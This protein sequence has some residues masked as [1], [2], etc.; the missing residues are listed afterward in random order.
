M[1][2]ITHTAALAII[3]IGLIAILAATY[4]YSRDTSRR[5]RALRLLRL[6]LRR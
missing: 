6:L 3:S 1:A 5:A 2:I 4:L